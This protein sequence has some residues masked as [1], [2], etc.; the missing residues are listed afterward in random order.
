MLYVR[1]ARMPPLD[2]HSP[3]ITELERALLAQELALTA[4]RRRLQ[5]LNDR[6]YQQ[7]RPYGV[8]L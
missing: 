8:L 4:L 5:D 7:L 1:T 2:S 3:E 6:L